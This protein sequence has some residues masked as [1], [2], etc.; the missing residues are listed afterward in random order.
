[1]SGVTQICLTVSG[2]CVVMRVVV[3]G[4][5]IVVYRSGS[6]CNQIKV[7]PGLDNLPAATGMYSNLITHRTT[8]T[9]NNETT[10][11]N[12]P[13]NHTQPT[14]SETY[15]YNTTHC[16]GTYQHEAITSRSR[17]LL[18][19]GTWLPETRWATIR[20]EIKNTQVTSSWFFLSTKIK[21]CDELDVPVI[22][23]SII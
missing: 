7:H 8:P 19:M 21:V 4:G 2:L 13:H 6:V 23:T 10:T 16:Y 17:Q 14:H 12:N 22:R 11:H 20:R 3:V 15:L 5:F 1:M 9:Y 18:M